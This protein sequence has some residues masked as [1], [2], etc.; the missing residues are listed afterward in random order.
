MMPD[1]KYYA[2]EHTFGELGDLRYIGFTVPG[3]HFYRMTT[4][5]NAFFTAGRGGNKKLSTPR[6]NVTNIRSFQIKFDLNE[7]EIWKKYINDGLEVSFEVVDDVGTLYD[8]YDFIGFDRKTRRY[9]T[10]EK[11]LRFNYETCQFV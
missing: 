7:L 2:S 5:L 6:P 4:S 3:Q 9:T 10:G 8:F 1:R 11:M